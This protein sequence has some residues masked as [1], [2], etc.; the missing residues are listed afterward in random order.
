MH[1]CAHTYTHERKHT[2]T[3]TL[4]HTCTHT[5][6]HTHAR[7]RTHTHTHKHTSTDTH[8]HPH[9]NTRTYTSE[10]TTH[11]CR[12]DFEMMGQNF[13]ELAVLHVASLVRGLHYGPISK[14]SRFLAPHFPPWFLVL[15]HVTL[16]PLC[17][18]ITVTFF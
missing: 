11:N 1:V 6:T 3:H 8:I 14:M 10:H 18:S 7:A 12:T 4:S 9:T 16:C 2:C 13:P 15:S 5:F 17:K